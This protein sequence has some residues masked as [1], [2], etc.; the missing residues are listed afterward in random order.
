MMS[1]PIKKM[2]SPAFSDDSRENEEHVD[3]LVVG[4]FD[5]NNKNLQGRFNPCQLR[6]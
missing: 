1:T 5:G 3:I 2:M 6:S 4:G